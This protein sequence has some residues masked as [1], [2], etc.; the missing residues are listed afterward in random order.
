MRDEKNHPLTLSFGHLVRVSGFKRQGRG[1]SARIRIL[2][3]HRRRTIAVVHSPRKQDQPLIRKPGTRNPEPGTR[4]PEPG[5]RIQPARSNHF[6]SVVRAIRRA[7][8][9]EMTFPG[10]GKTASGGR[11]AGNCARNACSTSVAGIEGDRTVGNNSAGAAG[12]R[13]RYITP[14]T[15]GSDASGPTTTSQP[16]PATPSS[17]S[18]DSS[19]SARSR[20]ASCRAVSPTAAT[21]TGASGVVRGCQVRETDG[22]DII[23]VRSSGFRVINA[24]IR[25]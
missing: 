4:N 22:E 21:P 20:R 18:S 15:Q 8:P 6:S 24:R 2:A 3:R 1:I 17:K 11:R 19:S 23:R 12:S 7:V 5:T 14:S 9:S 25:A 16:D 13:P 10:C